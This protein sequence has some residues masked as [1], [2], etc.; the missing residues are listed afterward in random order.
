MPDTLS[1]LIN[2][3]VWA[4][5]AVAI[6]CY[7]NLFSGISQQASESDSTLR[8]VQ[9]DQTQSLLNSLPLLG[10]LG[11]IIG[12]LQTFSAM[13]QGVGNQAE[14]MSSGIADAMFTTEIGLL[15]VI[16]GWLLLFQQRKTVSARQVHKAIIDMQG[17]ADAA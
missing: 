7:S 6:L 4:I 8:L 15:M 3:V 13:A 14:L 10:L 5:V 12:L 9:L 16:P 1:L 2:P 17:S 11:T